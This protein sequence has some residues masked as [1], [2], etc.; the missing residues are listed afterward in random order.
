MTFFK[1][2]YFLVYLTI[3]LASANHVEIGKYILICAGSTVSGYIPS[4]VIAVGQLAKAII[5]L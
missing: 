5:S 2:R 4:N 3:I 1:D